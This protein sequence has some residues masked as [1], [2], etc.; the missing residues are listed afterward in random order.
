MSLC[1]RTPHLGEYDP[2][3]SVPITYSTPSSTSGSLKSN[4]IGADNSDEGQQLPVQ[5][6]V[7]IATRAKNLVAIKISKQNIPY[8]AT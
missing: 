2:L 8:W 4:G 7:D 3:L 5:V 6:P 1:N